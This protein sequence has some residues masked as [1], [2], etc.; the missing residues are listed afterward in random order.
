[1]LQ[2][3]LP[4]RQNGDRWNETTQQQKTIVQEKLKEEKKTQRTTKNSLQM[5]M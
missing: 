1:M 5:E 4:N 3:P 2:D